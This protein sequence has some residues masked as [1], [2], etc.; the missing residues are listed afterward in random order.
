[1]GIGS[2]TWSS[3][4]LVGNQES[5]TAPV[6][7][8]SCLDAAYTVMAYVANN[9]RDHLLVT[10]TTNGTSWTRSTEVGD[11]QSSGLAPAL[12]D[13]TCSATTRQFVMTYVANNSN[14]HLLATTSTNGTTWTNDT[15]VKN[16]SE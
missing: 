2:S 8:D 13:N 1:L 11:G 4:I 7:A 16:G 3:S 9:S 12:A 15:K 10:T 6:L 14:H 5:Q